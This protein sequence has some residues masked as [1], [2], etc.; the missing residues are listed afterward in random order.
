MCGFLSPP[1]IFQPPS[2]TTLGDKREYFPLDAESLP[3]SLVKVGRWLWKFPLSGIRFW[4]LSVSWCSELKTAL[5]RKRIDSVFD[6]HVSLFILQFL[7]HHWVSCW[8][9]P[10]RLH[11]HFLWLKNQCLGWGCNLMVERCLAYLKS[12]VQSSASKLI[13]TTTTS[14][15]EPF[16]LGL[17][18]PTYKEL[19]LSPTGQRYLWLQETGIAREFRHPF[20]LAST[21]SHPHSAGVL[22]WLMTFPNIAG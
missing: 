5:P 15:T 12:W 7:P 1:W 9:H 3:L 21:L 18:Y 14:K 16:Q 22:D 20:P 19:H 8:L 10:L 2:L 13:I 17:L 11:L 4:T 6:P